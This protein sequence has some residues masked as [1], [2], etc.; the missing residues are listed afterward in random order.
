MTAPPEP[1]GRPSPLAAAADV[2]MASGFPT[3]LAL[4]ALLVAA[5]LLPF[6]ADGRMS[7]TYIALLMPADAALLAAFILWRLRAGGASPSAV[8]LGG[9]N[10]RRESWLGIGLIPVVL[11][12]VVAVMLGLRAAWPFLHNVDS[13]PFEALIGSRRDAV[14][15]VVLVI[16]TGGLKEELQRAFVLHRFEQSLG[17]ARTGLVL[18]SAVFGAGHI[19]QGYDVAI[20]TTLL[21][22]AWGAVFLRRRSLVAPAISH[23]GFNAAQVVQFALVGA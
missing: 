21:G 16:V 3:Q 1:A 23:A 4:G 5:G 22:V 7:V 8:L 2:V 15:F 11:A 14:L 19:I 9:R 12:G 20:V 6:D 10:V 17:G 18:Y 13:N